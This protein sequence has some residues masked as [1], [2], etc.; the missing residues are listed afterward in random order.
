M[1]KK[2]GHEEISTE[3][4]TFLAVTAEHFDNYAYGAGALQFQLA[5]A[6]AQL[7]AHKQQETLKVLA[8]LTAKYSPK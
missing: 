8:S 6:L 5:H 7:P 4:N 2:L 3:I 1:A